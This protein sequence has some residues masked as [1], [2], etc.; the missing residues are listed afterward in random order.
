[1]LDFSKSTFA[2]ILLPPFGLF[3]IPFFSFMNR[4]LRA[5]LLKE[6]KSV[7]S[8]DLT[9]WSDQIGWLICLSLLFFICFSLFTIQYCPSFTLLHIIIELKRKKMSFDYHHH[10]NFFP[11]RLLLLKMLQ[12]HSNGRNGGNPWCLVLV[13]GA[14]PSPSSSFPHCNP[15]YHH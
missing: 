7:L 15:D 3:F 5:Q 4:P 2:P 12:N 13:D 10:H 14:F 8:Y 9:M 6:K 1:M 11:L